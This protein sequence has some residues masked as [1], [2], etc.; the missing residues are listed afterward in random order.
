[1]NVETEPAYEKTTTINQQ[2]T[3]NKSKLSF[4]QIWN[5]NFGFL[6]IQFGWGLQMANISAI[7]EYLGANAHQL[8]ILWIA[9]PLTGLLIQPIIGN[10]SDSTWTPL[11]RRKPYF[12]LGAILAF[13]ALVLMP[14]SN[15]LL[16]AVIL[17]WILDS[18][19]NISMV[20][21]RAFV[22]D[23]LPQEQYTQ[24]FAMQS[25]M[26]G[27]G[28]VSASSLPWILNHLLGIENS[29]NS[30]H[31]VPLNVEIAFYFGAIVFL[32]T[33]L[34][35]VF[36]TP[37]FP[38]QNPDS[39]NQ[40]T[41]KARGVLGSI[42]EIR[43]AIEKMPLVMKHLAQIQFFTW[44][45]MFCFLL[46]FPP[47]VAHSIFGATSH[48]SALYTQGIQWAGLCL[49]VFHGVCIAFS[50][51]LPHLSNRIEQPVIHTI[52]LLCGG[53]GAISFL[54]I[55]NQYWLFFPMIAL[56]I[57][58]ASI[59]TIPYAILSDS[60]PPQQQGMYQGIFNFFIVLPQI[61]VSLSLGWIMNYVFHGDRLLAVVMGG[62]FMILA[63][64]L[65]MFYWAKDDFLL[66]LTPLDVDS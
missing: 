45:G 17:L 57:A 39:F 28:A 20:P 24:G 61:A 9:A 8:P 53:I 29:S 51:V 52:C 44:L 14:H 65:T 27:I 54:T 66:R 64:S 41:N 25:I 6:G 46:Y 47:G 13:I 4:W 43:I 50:L 56:G 34:W 1:M 35:T 37:E 16:M 63:A 55:D 59:H 5:M 62:V 11:G 15:S 49:A 10:L 26:V 7:F 19:A 48:T 12:L 23:L 2:K 60:L 32:V 58:W 21:F 22:G 38:P 40:S 3:I 33:I 30:L 42:Q 31:K 18:S 36:T